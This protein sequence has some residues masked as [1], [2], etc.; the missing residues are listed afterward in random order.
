VLEKFLQRVPDFLP[1]DPETIKEC[2]MTL[3]YSTPT[4]FIKALSYYDREPVGRF[5]QEQ[6]SNPHW[7]TRQLIAWLVTHYKREMKNP[8]PIIQ[9]LLSDEHVS[10][11]YV[12]LKMLSSDP[13]DEHIIGIILDQFYTNPPLLQRAFAL[14]LK[15]AGDRLEI[16]PNG[17]R[18]ILHS[19]RENFCTLGS[20]IYS[21]V[22]QNPI[23]ILLHSLHTTLTE[24]SPDLLQDLIQLRNFFVSEIPNA[25]VI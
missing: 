14:L 18:P 19:L 1:E 2:Y 10:V 15:H 3:L 23:R 5:I 21:P 12:A 17:V 22:N 13:L 16:S 8:I 25:M 4:E 7:A 6:I 11:R 24:P 20:K 9:R